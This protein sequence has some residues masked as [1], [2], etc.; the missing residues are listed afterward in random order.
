MGASTIDTDKTGMHVET[1][2]DIT[3]ILKMLKWD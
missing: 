3:Y 1:H 2:Y